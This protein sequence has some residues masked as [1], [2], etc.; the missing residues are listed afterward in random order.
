LV[1]SVDARG[2]YDGINGNDV[3]GW[4]A[5]GNRCRA[6]LQKNAMWLAL[7]DVA[8]IPAVVTVHSLMAF[9]ASTALF[10]REPNPVPMVPMPYRT[11]SRYARSIGMRPYRSPGPAR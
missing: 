1:V 10:S 8:L 5:V 2:C 6:V 9:T 4:N 3:M 7:W 11:L